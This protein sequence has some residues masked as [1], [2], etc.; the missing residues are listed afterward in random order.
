MPYFGSKPVD[1]TVDATI[2][3]DA[4][5]NT[6]IQ[7]EESSDENII[8]F[9]TAGT[10]AMRINADGSVNMTLQ[11]SF[12]GASDGQTN[13]AYNSYVT[14][15]LN[16][17]DH[18]VGSDLDL[19]NE[20]FTCPVDGV[21]MF[22]NQLLWNNTVSSYNYYHIGLKVNSG[23]EHMNLTTTSAFGAVSY[24]TMSGTNILSLSSGDTVSAFLRIDTTGSGSSTVDVSG[25]SRFCG[26]LLA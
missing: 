11:P 12:H 4:D 7:V 15:T 16:A 2:L 13:I 6:K 5:N 24:Y 22:V 23:Y 14:L 19:S 10:E 9:D 25:Y 26:H 17:E 20:T 21:Y 18:D 3:K 8:R 1:G